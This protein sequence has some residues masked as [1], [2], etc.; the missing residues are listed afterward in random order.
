MIKSKSARIII[1]MEC[2]NCRINKIQ[3]KKGIFRRITEKNKKNTPNRL[4]LK[5]Y[6][7]YCNSNYTYKEIK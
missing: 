3:N 2:Q 5:K 7:K 1:T 6:C 4:E